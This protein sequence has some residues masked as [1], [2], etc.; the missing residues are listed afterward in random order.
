MTRGHRAFLVN[1]Q[2]VV[3]I[4]AEGEAKVLWVVQVYG[5]HTGGMEVIRV[6]IGGIFIDI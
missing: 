2:G 5:Q 1:R 4:S 6:T 3:V